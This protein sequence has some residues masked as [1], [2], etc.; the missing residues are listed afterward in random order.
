MSGQVRS[1]K[2]GLGS[3][4]DKALKWVSQGGKG[5]EEYNFTKSRG[6]EKRVSYDKFVTKLC[7]S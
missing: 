5:S 2:V 3:V 1:G 7:K 6:G 4:G